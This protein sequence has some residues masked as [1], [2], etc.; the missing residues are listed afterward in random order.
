[1]LMGRLLLGLVKRHGVEQGRHLDTGLL[2]AQESVARVRVGLQKG[3][4]DPT[5]GRTWRG[6]LSPTMIGGDLVRQLSGCGGQLRL[7]V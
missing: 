6:V 1:M 3:Q 7:A 5:I 4:Q 2:W